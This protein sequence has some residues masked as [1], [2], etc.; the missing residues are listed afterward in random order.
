MGQSSAVNADGTQ[1][2][3][4]GLARFEPVK[5]TAGLKYVYSFNFLLEHDRLNRAGNGS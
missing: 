4:L 1:L 3:R 5:S 2:T